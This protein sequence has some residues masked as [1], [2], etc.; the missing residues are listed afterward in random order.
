MMTDSSD[1]FLTV[2]AFHSNRLDLIATAVYG[3][4]RWWWILAQINN[5][6]DVFICINS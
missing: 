5:I 3:E 6:L 1:T 2:D 4:P